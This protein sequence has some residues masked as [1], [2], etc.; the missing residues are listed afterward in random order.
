[1]STFIKLSQAILNSERKQMLLGDIPAFYI[2]TL[3]DDLVLSNGQN[4][5]LFASNALESVR[6][7]IKKASSQDYHYQVGLMQNVIAL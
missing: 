7:K 3:S 4:A 6:N 5:N 1:M 2:N